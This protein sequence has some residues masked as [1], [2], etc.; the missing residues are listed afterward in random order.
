[1]AR[2]LIG[3]P[4]C[5]DTAERI[6][7]G[8]RT[9]YIDEAYA[10]AIAEAGGIPVYLPQAS[11]SADAAGSAEDAAGRLD[12]LLVPGGDDFL[13]ERAYPETVRFDPV[14]AEQKERRGG[15]SSES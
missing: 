12:G 10:R 7:S 8:R 14:P 9:H 13:P 11:S 1:M 5:L 6:R 15:W 4:P 2:P 3:I